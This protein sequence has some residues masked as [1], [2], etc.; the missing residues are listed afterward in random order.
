MNALAARDRWVAID[1]GVI[2]DT[3]THDA[4]AG[5]TDV[6]DAILAPGFIDIQINGIADVDFSRMDDGGYARAASLLLQHGVTTFL[7]TLI[8]APLPA[9]AASLDALAD[10]GAFGVHLEGPFLGGAPGAH[11]RDYLI[12]TDVEWSLAQL[13]RHAGLVKIV[14]IAPE[15]DPDLRLTKELASRGV[16]VS[17]G[18]STC[19][20]DEARAAC[21]RGARAV[22]HLYNAMSGLHHREPGVVGAALDDDRLTPSLIAD[23]VHVH[24]AALKLAIARKRNVAL[25]S[26]AIA[27]DARW[28][29][30]RGVKEIDGAPRLPDGTLAGSTLTLERAI[31]NVVAHGVG[32]DRAIEMASTIPAE[33]LGLDDRGTLDVGKRADIVALEPDDLSVRS[34]WKD[35]VQA[36]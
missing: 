16:V 31:R 33:L 13:D 19:T 8:S 22:T 15:A 23:L 9:M 28:A 25:I 36:V 18:H 1:N 21:D 3:G 24:P 14:T 4:P 26:D 11:I 17:V 27:I 5:A 35:G 32:V 6:G 2:V 20:Y 30:S 7:P 12:E 34:V 29:A 10:A